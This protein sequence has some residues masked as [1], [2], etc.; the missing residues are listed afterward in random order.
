MESTETAALDPDL[1]NCGCYSLGCQVSC[2]PWRMW[3]EDRFVT[4]VCLFLHLHS[5]T[6]YVFDMLEYYVLGTLYGI[7][8]EVITHRSEKEF[9]K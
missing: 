9:F 6:K 1:I 7:M 5:I 8:S 2:H 4:L 3:Q